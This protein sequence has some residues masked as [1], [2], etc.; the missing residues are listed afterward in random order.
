MLK[1][2]IP[3]LCLLPLTVHAG[4]NQ[5]DLLNFDKQSEFKNFAK[6][7]TGAL[8]YKTLTPAEP[9]G[10]SGFDIGASYTNSGLNYKLMDKVTTEGNGSFDT[11]SLHAVKGLPWGIDFGLDY[12]SVMN[13]NIETWGGKLSYA[14]IEG[15]ALY[16][17]VSINGNYTQTSGLSAVDFK[18]MGAE[19]GVSKGFANLTPYA[20]LG[21]TNGELKSLIDNTGGA[22]VK[23]NSESVSMMKYAIG[24]NINL[25]TMDVLV[26]YNQ[27]GEVPSYSLKAGF[28]F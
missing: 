3:L 8:G 18:S 24:V 22:G 20:A 5:V 19:I 17:S 10:V 12:S 26:G 15:G 28:R 27:I 25:L 1:K 6:D 14:L 21:M 7:F 4:N 16:P 23:L 9:L 11:I 13:S 2:L